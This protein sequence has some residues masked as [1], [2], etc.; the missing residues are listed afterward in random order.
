M[1]SNRPYN[2]STN[3]AQAA[4]GKSGKQVAL[5][6]VVR[7]KTQGERN[8]FYA[9]S[10]KEGQAAEKCA[11]AMLRAL[12]LAGGAAAAD[13]ETAGAFWVL[14]RAKAPKAGRAR[15]AVQP[16]AARAKA[17]VKA[18]AE[19][20]TGPGTEAKGGQSNGSS[21]RHDAMDPTP[22]G[23]PPAA[24]RQHLAARP[25]EA[26]SGPTRCA[27][28]P[29]NH[30][31]RHGCCQIPQNEPQQALP[32]ATRLSSQH[33]A[34]AVLACGHCRCR[35]RPAAVH[36][37]TGRHVPPPNQLHAALQHTFALCPPPARQQLP[38]RQPAP[39]ACPPQAHCGTQHTCCRA[40][41][42]TVFPHTTSSI[43]STTQ[44]C[45]RSLVAAHCTCS[46]SAPLRRH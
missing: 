31:Q 6:F 13:A 40:A 43:A 36:A 3:M 1:Q 18:E 38:L 16:G 45:S 41:Q 7:F 10:G 14:P 33:C 20:G 25:L 5:A 17:G 27:L 28:H 12:G 30:T 46:S 23:E 4:A 32:T 21:S 39:T 9:A 22:P 37:Q 15:L 34:P 8:A 44:Q 35:Q 42:Q 11:H 29:C 2:H 24:V 26:G 19:Q